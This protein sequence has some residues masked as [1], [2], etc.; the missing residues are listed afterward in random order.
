MDGETLFLGRPDAWDAG[1]WTQMLDAPFY[2]RKLT[3]GALDAWGH[4]F[5]DEN[6]FVVGNT[7]KEIVDGWRTTLLWMETL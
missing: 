2:G 1:L 7:F 4:P 3:Y 5:M 6:P